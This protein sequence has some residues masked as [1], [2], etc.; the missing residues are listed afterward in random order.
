[1]TRQGTSKGAFKIPPIK[2]EITLRQKS[3]FAVQHMM[4]AARFSRMCGDVEIQHKGE[5]LGSFFDEQIT[6]VSATVLLATASIESNIN[7][8]FSDPNAN[9]PE[10]NKRVFDEMLPLIEEESIPDK[11]QLA[12]VLKGKEKFLKDCSPFQDT[13]ALIKLRNALVHFRPEWHDEQDLH[14][15]IE[16]RLKG[17]FEINP[18]IGPNGVF[19]PQQCMSYGCTKWAVQTAL[20]FMKEFSTR[21]GL[22][23]RFEIFASRLNPRSDKEV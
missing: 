2:S 22:P 7:E 14:K 3:A 1:M 9:F 12:L 5:P 6:Y 11:Y 10:I 8:Y 17:R 20:G 15:K 18:F 16:G 19:F 23:Y 21:S 4:A 13:E